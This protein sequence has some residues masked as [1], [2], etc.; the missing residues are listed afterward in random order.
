MVMGSE[1]HY[2]VTDGVLHF[3]CYLQ[4]ADSPDGKRAENGELE[5]NPKKE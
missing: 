5:V 3:F 4:M 2:R 1:M